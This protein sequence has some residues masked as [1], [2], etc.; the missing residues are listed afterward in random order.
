MVTCNIQLTPRGKTLPE[1]Q[2]VSQVAKKF[3]SLYK[4]G[5]LTWSLTL[6]TCPYPEPEQSSSRPPTYFLK[7][8]FNIVL[9]STRITTWATHSWAAFLRSEETADLNLLAD[10]DTYA[11]GSNNDS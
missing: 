5:S 6:A 8:H 9:P 2:I 1:K 4:W 3:P 7:I 11:T 10:L